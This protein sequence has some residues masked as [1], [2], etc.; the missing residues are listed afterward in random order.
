MRER[1]RKRATSRRMF[2]PEHR[3]KHRHDRP[4]KNRVTCLTA[5]FGLSTHTWAMT[6]PGGK[7]KVTLSA[8]GFIDNVRFQDTGRTFKASHT[9]HKS[10]PSYPRLSPL[11]VFKP[12]P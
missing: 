9:C 10:F 1:E 6:A 3:R 7:D 12:T 4:R 2:S 5:H 8:S 11:G